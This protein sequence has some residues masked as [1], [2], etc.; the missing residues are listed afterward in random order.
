[1]PTILVIDDE[2]SMREFLSIMLEKEGYKVVAM[3]N[4]NDALDYIRKSGDPLTDSGHG[5]DLI[6]SDIKMPR[7]SGSLQI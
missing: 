6:I 3:D 1:M 7:I 5:F 4:G 2:R